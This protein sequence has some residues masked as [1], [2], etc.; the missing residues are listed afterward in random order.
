MPDGEK[1]EEPGT[2][3]FAVSGRPLVSILIPSRNQAALLES[4]LRSLRKNLGESVSYEIIIVLNAATDEVKSFAPS[5]KFTNPNGVCWP[6]A[7]AIS[8]A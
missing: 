8:T 3:T 5:L 7:A 2:I 6:K 1:S 4:C